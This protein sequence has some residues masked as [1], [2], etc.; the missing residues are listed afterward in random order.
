MFVNTQGIVWYNLEHHTARTGGY[1]AGES[2]F[3][4]FFLKIILRNSQN[5][6]WLFKKSS[7][8]DLDEALFLARR[9]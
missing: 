7:F 4:R 1:T 2:R 3:C 9:L 6:F 5:P 8:F